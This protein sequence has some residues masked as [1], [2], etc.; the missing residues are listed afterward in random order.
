[1]SSE[2]ICTASKFHIKET[3]ED[4]WLG[5]RPTASQEQNRGTKKVPLWGTF[6]AAARGGLKKPVLDYAALDSNFLFSF[7]SI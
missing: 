7:G 4:P 5:K 2:P 3:F 1:M 6:V